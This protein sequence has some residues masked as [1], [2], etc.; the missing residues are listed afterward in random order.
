MGN[1]VRDGHWCQEEA[2]RN[3]KNSQIQESEEGSFRCASRLI[4]SFQSSFFLFFISFHHKNSS[5]FFL[6]FNLTRDLKTGLR[7]I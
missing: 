3:H 4:E 2:E 7:D 5:P 1:G 6:L